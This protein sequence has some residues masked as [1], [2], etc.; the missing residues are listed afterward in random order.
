MDGWKRPSALRKEVREC[1]A[2]CH[3][4]VGSTLRP[5]RRKE[6]AVVT[7]DV[8]PDYSIQRKDSHRRHKLFTT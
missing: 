4:M 2:A 8:L 5:Q 3:G 6:S 1:G 7:A